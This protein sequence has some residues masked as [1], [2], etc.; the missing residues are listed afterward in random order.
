MIKTSRT[1]CDDNR[2]IMFVFLPHPF[3]PRGEGI[4][5][6]S[7]SGRKKEGQISINTFIHPVR[8]RLPL[9]NENPPR[10]SDT[11]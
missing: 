8:L 1:G 9:L 3:R 6:F 11:P 4:I 7:P 5:K 10:P 2:N